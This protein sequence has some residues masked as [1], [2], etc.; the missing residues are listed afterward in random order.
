MALPEN[1]F[2][3]A[4]YL[5]AWKYHKQSRVQKFLLQR[6]RMSSFNPLICEFNFCVKSFCLV[7]ASFPNPSLLDLPSRSERTK[8]PITVSNYF[9]LRSKLHRIVVT[10][11]ISCGHLPVAE[12]LLRSGWRTHY[13]M[14]FHL[15]WL[16]PTW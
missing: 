8:S 12:A 7:G 2:Q 3:N 4:S 1:G 10:E 6:A 9:Q 14:G 11:L 16:P 15:D 5:S 13:R